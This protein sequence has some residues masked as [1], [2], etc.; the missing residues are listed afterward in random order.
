MLIFK[1]SI[2]IIIFIFLNKIVKKIYI[3]FENQ[4]LDAICIVNL[5][6]NQFYN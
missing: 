5:Q 3:C 4:Y 2:K 6:K 1:F